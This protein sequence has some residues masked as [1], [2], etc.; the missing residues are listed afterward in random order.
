MKYL[1]N[2]DEFKKIIESVGV[3]GTWTESS[4]MLSYRA[5]DGGIINLYSTGTVQVQGNKEAKVLWIEVVENLLNNLSGSVQFKQEVTNVI[6]VCRTDNAEIKKKVF[7]VYGHD[8]VSRDQLELILMKL[9][10]EPFILSNTGGGGNTLIEALEAEIIKS[11]NMCDFGI[12]LMT[13]DDM[14]YAIS[15]GEDKI[16]F[17]AR[18]NVVLEM[19]MLLSALSRDKVA[20]LK[21]GHLELPSDTNG[22]IYIPF[23]THVKECV[24][25][26]VDRL[27]N[28]G[29]SISQEQITKASS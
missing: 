19:G 3:M 2:K 14:G 24:P 11:N 20:I 29:F 12:V 15:E 27:I 18:Q 22:I 8:S 16:D 7:V 21:K 1:G 4:G 26:L 25:R 13:P 9:G 10:L 6:P 5:V 28:S 23:N 17:R